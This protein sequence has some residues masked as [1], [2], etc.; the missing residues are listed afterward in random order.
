M[1]AFVSTDALPHSQI[2]NSRSWREY[3]ILYHH[4]PLIPVVLLNRFLV[5]RKQSHLLVDCIHVGAVY[6]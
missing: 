4:G 3:V 1:Q 2:F 6:K 5:P